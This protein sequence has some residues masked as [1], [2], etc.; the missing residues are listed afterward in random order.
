MSTISPIS[1]ETGMSKLWR[2]EPWLVRFILLAPALVFT[3][4]GVR[5]LVD[6]VGTA[7]ASGFAPASALGLTNLR[8]GIGGLFLGAAWITLFCLLSPRR[9]LGGLGFV[10]SMMGVVLGVRLVSVVVDGTARA[11]L[12]VLGAEAVFLILA[13]AGIFLERRRRQPSSA[14]PS[15]EA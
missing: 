2:Y 6:P 10:A 14:A 1:K 11:S 15:P 9:L 4:I 3:S 7:A 8:S 12:P 5:F 13:L